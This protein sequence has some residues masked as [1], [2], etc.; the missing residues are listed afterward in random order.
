MLENVSSNLYKSDKNVR[1]KR[2]KCMPGDLC[3]KGKSKNPLVAPWAIYYDTITWQGIACGWVMDGCRMTLGRLDSCNSQELRE[4]CWD[5][6]FRPK[7]GNH[8]PTQK[9]EVTPLGRSICWR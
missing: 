3:C 2:G 7:I 8:S 4:P 1:E 6:P 5:I 9:H